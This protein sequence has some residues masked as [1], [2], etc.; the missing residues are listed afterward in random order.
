MG[1]NARIMKAPNQIPDFE[2]IAP[3]DFIIQAIEA[4][5]KKTV[6][7]GS[8]SFQNDPKG[9]VELALKYSWHRLQQ[10]TEP[11][12]LDLLTIA[13]PEQNVVRAQV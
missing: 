5:V 10:E 13:E 4:G 11:D 7:N 3:S 2:N 8:M 1:N 6:P 12:D 9:T